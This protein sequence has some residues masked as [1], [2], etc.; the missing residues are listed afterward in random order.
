MYKARTCQ[1]CRY[2]ALK[3]CLLVHISMNFVYRVACLQN[4]GSGSG[5]G[6]APNMRQGNCCNQC[7]PSSPIQLIVYDTTSGC[8]R[9][10]T[11]IDIETKIACFFH[12]HCPVE[13]QNAK[14]INKNLEIHTV[15][16]IVPWPNPKQWQMGHTS[17][18]MIIIRW[19]THILTIIVR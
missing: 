10:C 11:W 19:S 15:Q 16:T 18:L 5:N 13:T 14:A 9:E 1:N 12:Q 3:I 17:D 6:L 2:Y 7:R 8:W 4:A